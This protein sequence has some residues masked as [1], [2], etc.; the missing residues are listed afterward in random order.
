MGYTH[1]WKQKKYFTLADWTKICEVATEAAT[2]VDLAFESD[3]NKPP[4][5]DKDVI[6]FNGIGE[7]GGET[8]IISQQNPMLRNFR[9]CKTARKPYDFAVVEILNAAYDTGKMDIS[10]DGDLVDGYIVHL[11]GR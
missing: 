2:L 9:F 7:N 8:F 4:Q 11:R 1:Y 10:T 3:V 6:C 5:I